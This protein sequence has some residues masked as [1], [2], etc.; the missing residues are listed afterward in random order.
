MSNFPD[1]VNYND[2]DAPWNQPDLPSWGCMG[3]SIC[4]K[5]DLTGNVNEEQI[6]EGCFEPKV[7][8]E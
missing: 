8:I 6:C 3:F 7:E 5:C 1:T 4:K 2:K